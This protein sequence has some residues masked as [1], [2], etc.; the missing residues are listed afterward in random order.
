MP[1]LDADR[2]VSTDRRQMTD[3]VKTNRVRYQL[4]VGGASLTKEAVLKFL[5]ILLH[6]VVCRSVAFCTCNVDFGTKS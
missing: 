3:R 1:L 5:M 2:I 6:L 4:I